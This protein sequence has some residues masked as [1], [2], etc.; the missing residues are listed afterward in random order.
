MTPLP[1][2]LLG[3]SL[4]LASFP[5]AAGEFA[6][7]REEI[8]AARASLVSMV[9][10]RDRR[11]PLEQKQVKDTADAV[12]LHLARLKAPQGRSA[13]FQELVATW[14]AFKATREKELVPAI[15]ANDTAKV[16]RLGAVVQKE[17]LDRMYA[18]L[19][20]LEP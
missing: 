9:T 17:R 18:L 13:E 14:N 2:L 15:L 1:A 11:G 8:S 19:K 16:T 12:S 10:N 5:A 7:L 6:T 20:A 3:A 4:L